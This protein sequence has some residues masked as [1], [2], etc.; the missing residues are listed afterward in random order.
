MSD[1]LKAFFTIP[2]IISLARI[3]MVP[4]IVWTFLTDRVLSALILVILSGVSDKLDGVIA[5]KFNMISETGKWLD[6]VAD[7]ITQV[8]LALLLFWRFFESGDAWMRGTSWIFLGFVA[9]EVVMLLVGLVMLLLGHRPV[10]AELWGKVATFIFYLVMGLLLFAG[11]EIGI[12][13][14]YF[15]GLSMPMPLTQFL[16][17]LSL[18]MTI[19]AFLSYIPGT[20]RILFKEGKE[21]K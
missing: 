10:A 6:P 15:S 11:P 17:I 7:K 13:A 19:I 16:V 18:I 5:R 1:K 12:L 8:V 3:L 20:Y 9:K 2:N 14:N 4:F 21:D